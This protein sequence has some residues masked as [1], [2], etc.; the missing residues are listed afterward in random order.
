MPL[1]K[2][3]TKKPARQ[4]EEGLIV[5]VLALVAVPPAAWIL[6]AIFNALIF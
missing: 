1:Y 6:A 4:D 2:I 3:P 5:L